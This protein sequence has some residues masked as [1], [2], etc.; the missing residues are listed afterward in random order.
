MILAILVAMWLVI[1]LAVDLNAMFLPSPA[2]VAQ[3]AL[4]ELQSGALVDNILSTLGRVAFAV[5]IGAAVGIPL[6]LLCSASK[7]MRATI[8]PVID[9]LRSIPTT[10]LFPVFIIFLGIGE[11]A[12]VAIAVYATLPIFAVSAFVGA[13]SRGEV[14]GRREYLRI[15][16]GSLGVLIKAC[17]RFWDALPS[18]CAGSRVAISIALVLVVV[19]EM[20]FSASS[21]AGWGAYQAYLAFSIDRMYAYILIIGSI[22][23]CF[24]V[25]LD[26]LTSTVARI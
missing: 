5:G 26:R 9:F 3:E 16:A 21:G 17:A 20:F 18:I 2:G 15:H 11:A 7:T 25:M 22:G 19:T 10:L 14:A 4:A 24:N 12:R 8:I 6:G 1:A 23:Y 13:S